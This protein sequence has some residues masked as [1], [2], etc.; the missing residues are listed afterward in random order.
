MAKCLSRFLDANL[1]R[2]KM[3]L[4]QG[5]DGCI[6][7]KYHDNIIPSPEYETAN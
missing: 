5:I 3:N 7:L 2:Q 6:M 4:P 1:E